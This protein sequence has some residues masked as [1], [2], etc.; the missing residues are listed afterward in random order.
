M[1]AQ[2]KYKVAGLPTVII[3]D[4][5]GVEQ[6]RFTDFVEAPEFHEA[7]REVR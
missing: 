5:D 4:S 7:I 3:I 2:K 6:K 1:D